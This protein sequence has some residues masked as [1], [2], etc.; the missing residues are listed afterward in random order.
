MTLPDTL[1][2]GL[3]EVFEEGTALAAETANRQADQE[4]KKHHA[5]DIVPVKEFIPPGLSGQFL[6][7]TPRSPTQHRNEAEY[8]GQGVTVND[9]HNSEVLSD[10]FVG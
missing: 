4:R 10:L 6:G 2:I 9:K 1:R 8:D 7:I 5:D 3:C